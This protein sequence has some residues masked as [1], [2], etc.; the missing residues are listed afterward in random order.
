MAE[1]SVSRV[2]GLAI[3]QWLSSV[4]CHLGLFNMEICFIK[5]CK[6]RR[7]KRDSP[8]NTKVK[9]FSYLITEVIHHHLCHILLVSCKSLG[10]AHTHGEGLYKSIY[11]WRWDSLGTILEVRLH[12]YLKASLKL[13]V[14]VGR[15]VCLPVLECKASKE[16]VLVDTS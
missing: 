1:F 10:S 4:S 5:A 11:I 8:G 15:R 7:Q 3:G 12:H 14:C 13:H 2:T 6:S 16:D 9:T